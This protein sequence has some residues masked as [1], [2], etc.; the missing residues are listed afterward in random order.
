MK[1]TIAVV[2]ATGSQGGGLCQAL[3]AMPDA[4][5]VR[6]LTRNPESEKAKL[7]SAAGAH[8]VQADLDD[9][10]SLT[11]AFEGTDGVFGVTNYWE[12]QSLEREKA[13]AQNIA[14]ACQN[15]VVEHVVWSTLED[16]RTFIP[17]DFDAM[18]MLDEVY[19]VPHLDGKSEADIFFKDL[20]TTYLITSFFGTT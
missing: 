17:S 20:P 6:A 16:T 12:H 19:R 1:K 7:L 5:E 10:A 11:V 8:V 4:F 3:L 2:G 14:L 13:Q 18:P 15:S 9:L